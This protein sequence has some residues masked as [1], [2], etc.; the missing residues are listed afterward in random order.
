MSKM[1]LDE[2]RAANARC[3]NRFCVDF[4]LPLI[5]DMILSWSRSA[6]EPWWFLTHLKVF[7]AVSVTL[8]FKP[9]MNKGGTVSH[10]IF[11]LSCKNHI[12]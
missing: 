2:F 8:I 11:I 9:L 3:T 4:N 6:E 7:H 5:R 10:N 12:Q 1:W